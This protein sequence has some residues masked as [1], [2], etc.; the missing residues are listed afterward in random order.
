[1]DNRLMK[2]NE[3]FLRTY[4]NGENKKRDWL[5]QKR[6]TD[7][8]DKRFKKIMARKNIKDIKG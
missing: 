6:K 8:V 2:Q 7:M 3:Y 5:I 4:N 1:M